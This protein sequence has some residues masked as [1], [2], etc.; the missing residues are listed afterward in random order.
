MLIEF[1]LLVELDEPHSYVDDN[2]E[3]KDIVD[4]VLKDLDE[5]INCS[6]FSLDDSSWRIVS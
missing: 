4:E 3:G 2:T 5:V 6:S 1:T